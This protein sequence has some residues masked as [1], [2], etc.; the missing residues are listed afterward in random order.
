MSDGGGGLGI[1][2]NAL[3]VL[4]IKGNALQHTREVVL[5]RIPNLTELSIGSAFGIV[6]K[7]TIHDVSL[8]EEVSRDEV[9]VRNTRE[10]QNGFR[11]TKRIV[12]SS[13]CFPSFFRS[14]DMGVFPALKELVVGKGCL[15]YVNGLKLVGREYL[16][17][18]EIGD[19]CFSKAEG[20][21]EVRDCLKLR[22]VTIGWNC[23]ALWKE[24]LLLNCGVE[25]VEIGS[26]CFSA[27]EGRLFILDCLQ[28]KSINI[29]DDSFV[30]WV[31]FAL[32]SCGVNSV[33]IGDGCF[34]SCE[35]TAF[36]QL[37]ELKSLKIGREVF[38]GMEGKKNELYMMSERLV[39]FLWVDLNELTVMLAG[40]KALKNVQQVQLTTIPKLVKLTLRGAFLGA[41][42]G[43]VKNASKFEEVKELKGIK[44]LEEITETEN[45]NYAFARYSGIELPCYL[46]TELVIPS[47]CCNEAEWSVFDVSGLKRLKRI[48]IGDE[49]FE[50]VKEVKL[51]G[52]NRLERVVIGKN[53]FTKEKNDYGNDP[54]RHFYLKKC[55]RVRELKIGHHS[56]SDYSV[57]EIENV[58]SLEV[59]E[60]GDLN[61]WSSNFYYASLELKSDSE[62]MK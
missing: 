58:P 22:S 51:I 44:K 61:E 60:I 14:I 30:N 7:A 32:S 45:N 49:C 3:E 23:C 34:V 53:S 28:L 38:Q 15:K 33:E 42:E 37:K 52:L 17:R 41:K 35:R 26:G 4:C 8:L 36:V 12:F 29:G 27:A 55:E 57:C 46:V 48:E 31:E 10:L 19:G 6:E 11:F 24:F 9:I 2:L 40:M 56:F 18:L 39:S 21:L 43:L 5:E 47:K 13:S 25:S 59:I 54:N 20:N 1:D 62:R 16:E 50:N